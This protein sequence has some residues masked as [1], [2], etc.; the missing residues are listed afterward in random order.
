MMIRMAI[1][2]SNE[3]YIQRLVSVLEDYEGLTLSVYT[4]TQ[5]LE[6]ALATRKFDIILFD[7]SI[8]DG[9]TALGRSSLAILLLDESKGVPE[10]C[11]DLPK[12]RKYQRISRI[13]QQVI[14]LYAEIA[15]ETG[16]VL[17]QKSVSLITFYSPVGG[18]GKTTAALVTATKLARKGLNTLY[19]NFEEI[20]SEDCYLPQTGD[21]GMSE[22]AASLGSGVN[23]KMKIQ[24][25]LQTKMENLVYINHFDSPNDVE[26]LSGEEMTE[27]LDQMSKTGIFDYIVVDMGVAL[28]QK[29]LSVFEIS[30][31]IVLVERP[32][33][34]GAKKMERFLS[35][36]HIIN[37]Y[38]R[39]MCR[40]L[41]FDNGHAP[42]FDTEI[43]RIGRIGTAQNMDCAQLIGALANSSSIHFV[44]EL[45]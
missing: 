32:G 3:E 39:K 33:S 10:S 21:K 25:L 41:N 27:L 6:T 30:Q 19:V 1:A 34:I 18:S 8:Y 11:R 29:L 16:S 31:K 38:G 45:I 44:S 24:S 22:V 14:E 4:Q 12:V 37:N 23:F 5:A 20:A 9:Q 28:N 43:P 13:Y 15:G 7:A 42:E 36:A 40:L 35:Q 2:D 26:E 17:G